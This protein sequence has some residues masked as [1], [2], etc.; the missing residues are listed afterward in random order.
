MQKS[1]LLT[2]MQQPKQQLGS[3][4]SNILFK[5]SKWNHKIF[6]RHTGGYIRVIAV[7]IQTMTTLN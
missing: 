6:K 5:K 3:K 2:D 1:H 4:Q 7:I